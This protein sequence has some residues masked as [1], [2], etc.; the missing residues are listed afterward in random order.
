[1]IGDGVIDLR[2]EIQVLR[3]IGYEGAIS[4]EL[5]NQKLWS[6]DPSE[7]LK[8]GIDRMRGLLADT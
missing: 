1:M 4:L 7:V 5:F 2:S 8:I 6:Q 3:E